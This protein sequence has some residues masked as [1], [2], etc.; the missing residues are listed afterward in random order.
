MRILSQP[1]DFVNTPLPFSRHKYQTE[2]AGV[3]T[4]DLTTL[5]VKT[6]EA[7]LKTFMRGQAQ[8][9]DYDFEGSNLAAL[10]RLLAYNTGLNSFFLNMVHTEGFLD[11]A[12]NR[13]SLVSRAKELNY[14]PRSAR[15]ARARIKLEFNGTQPS[16]LIEKGRTFTSIVHDNGLLF[17]VPENLLLTST[18]GKFSVETDI[19]EGSYVADSYVVNYAEETQRF[20][21]TNPNVDTR[22]L[23]VAVFEDGKVE[24]DTYR[25][26]STLLGLNERSKVYFLQAS[27]T[28]HYEVVF[29]DNVLGYRPGD[30]ATVILDYRVTRGSAGNGAK[31]FSLDFEIGPGATGHKLSTEAVAD[32]G[33]EPEDNESIRYY[34]PRHFQIQERATVADDYAILLKSEFPEIRAVSCYGGED[35]NPPLYGRVIIAIDV[36]DVDGIPQS[37]KDEYYRFLKTRNSMTIKPVFVEPNYTYVSIRSR[38]KYNINVTTLKDENI[39]TLVSTNITDFAQE[40]LNDFNATLRYSRLVGVIDNAHAS[41]VGNQ[42]ELQVYKKLELVTETP[43]SRKVYFGMKLYDGYPATGTSFPVGD[44][45]TVRSSN[46][47]IGAET[48]YLTDDGDGKLWVATDKDNKTLLLQQVGTVDYWNGV[49]QITNL[50][51]QALDGPYLKLYAKPADL[52]VRS[53]ADT[54]LE[55]EADE[56]QVTVE[57]IRE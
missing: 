27:E 31:K 3:K 1:V 46:Y 53:P 41:V 13:S 33:D 17:S 11:S 35:A 36:T 38:V 50:T 55:V 9:K 2:S 12:Q 37:K 6:L 30:G 43:Q 25:K 18:N 23:T 5:D 24:G 20:I 8:F 52:D 40:H 26:A 39:S 7:N 19:Y 48:R 15:S 45:R 44:T 14:T 54:I 16:Y 34:A 4:L 28:G 42:T 49:V 57:A 29:G 56:I 51:V 22:S 47:R 10:I 32:G 21:L